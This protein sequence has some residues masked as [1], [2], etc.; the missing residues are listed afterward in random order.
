M[1]TKVECYDVRFLQARSQHVPG[2]PAGLALLRGFIHLPAD[3]L[4]VE[5]LPILRLAGV[6]P[7]LGVP[8]PTVFFT[9]CIV[10]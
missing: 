7:F 1:S 10:I 3:E 2:G 9:L 6:I 5:L 4:A 8:V